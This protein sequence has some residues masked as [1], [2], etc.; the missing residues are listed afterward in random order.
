MLKSR[1]FKD[2]GIG[3]LRNPFSNDVQVVKNEVAVKQALFTLVKMSIFEAPFS[4]LIGSRLH[5]LL[6]DNYT[7]DLESA[8][9]SELTTLIKNYE[10]RVELLDV[11][12]AFDEDNNTLTITLN[13]YIV[14]YPV[15]IES[16][17]ILVERSF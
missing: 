1:S 2:L 17:D 13:Y 9:R 4:P 8:V 3:L 15:N 16:L 14:G 12:V 7:F 11:F 5:Q 6:F 10:P